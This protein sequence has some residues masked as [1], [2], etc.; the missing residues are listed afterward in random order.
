VVGGD[1]D[2]GEPRSFK[3]SRILG[4]VT[5][6]GEAEPPPPEF[7]AADHLTAGP[8]GVGEPERTARVAFTS[9]VAA[10]ALAALPQ[11]RT[12]APR[13]DG[14]VEAAVPAG[15][16]DPFVSWILSFGP[17]AEVLEPADLREAVV[18][19]LEEIRGAL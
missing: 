19:A 4:K 1:R 3:L 2:R 17:D 16:E 8:W 14:W 5:D 7:R 10:S 6:S 15:A 11:A 13:E 12:D 9:K 18:H